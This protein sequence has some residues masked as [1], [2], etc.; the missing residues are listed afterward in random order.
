MHVLHLQKKSVPE[1]RLQWPV[2][3]SADK[4]RA[5]CIIWL[6]L[7]LGLG[8]RRWHRWSGQALPRHCV[9]CSPVLADGLLGSSEYQCTR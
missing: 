5:L 8:S 1:P 7:G 9:A 4:S 6:G 2:I 3:N